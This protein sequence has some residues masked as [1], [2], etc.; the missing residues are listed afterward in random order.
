MYTPDPLTF[1][2]TAVAPNTPVL[3]FNGDL[4]AQTPH[5]YAQYTHDDLQRTG[6]PATL[7]SIPGAPH[8]TILYSQTS[9]AGAPPCAV[10]VRCC[11]VVA[12]PFI[13]QS[14]S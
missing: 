11:A 9:V 8:G 7:I 12:A 1:N 14:W 10:Q 13:S 5:K 6:T 2:T 3:L 4:D